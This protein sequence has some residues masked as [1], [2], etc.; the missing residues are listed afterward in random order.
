[1]SEIIHAYCG[2]DCTDCPA[3][4]AKQTDDDDLRAITAEKWSS[5]DF[6]VSPEDINCGGCKTCEEEL[7]VV[8]KPCTLRPCAQQR[9]VETCA[10]CPDFI[11]EILEHYFQVAGEEARERLTKIHEHLS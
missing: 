7:S 1:M 4:I 9:N 11:C 6:P 5:P 2:I 8:T 3:Y 10:H